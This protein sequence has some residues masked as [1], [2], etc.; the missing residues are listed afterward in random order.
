MAHR[1]KS[2]K[3]CKTRFEVEQGLQLPVGFFCSM[4][5][6]MTY[7]KMAQNRS[8]SNAKRKLMS[9]QPSKTK[10]THRGSTDTK[11]QDVKW[12]HKRT[13]QA[14]NKMRVLE[15]LVWF[16]KRGREPT[17]ISCDKPLGGDQWCCGHFKTIGAHG[18]LRYD[19]RNTY[20]QH[21]HRCNMHMSGD[22]YGTNTTRGM[23]QGIKD[24]FGEQEGQRIIDYCS[25]R[26]KPAK[27]DWQDL[28]RM[29]KEFNQKRRELE[30]QIKALHPRRAIPI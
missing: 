15:E 16:K 13:Q 11:R 28:E 4:N 29:R 27:W 30:K 19:R 5:H 3:H 20:L 7:A 6:A 24:R 2:C 21:N 14:F 22:L 1:T 12:Q 10:A 8:R 17:C 9:R 23:V 25:Q 18:A 26:M